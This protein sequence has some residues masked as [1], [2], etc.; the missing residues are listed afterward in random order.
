MFPG[1]QA[2]RDGNPRLDFPARMTGVRR[3][4]MNSKPPSPPN[5][6]GARN[7]LGDRAPPSD[8]GPIPAR[9][10]ARRRDSAAAPGPAVRREPG[11]SD[12]RRG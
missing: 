11:V 8:L 6:D 9:A 3:D 1:H 7:T 12:R 5:A 2:W 10:W 4:R